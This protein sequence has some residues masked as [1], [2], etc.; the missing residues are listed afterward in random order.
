MHLKTRFLKPRNPSAKRLLG[1]AALLFSCLHATQVQAADSSVPDIGSILKGPSV[2]ASPATTPKLS[3][4]RDSAPTAVF[5]DAV[6]IAVTNFIISGN[7]IFKDEQLRPLLEHLRGKSWT[8]AQLMTSV[9][10]ITAFYEQAG[11]PLVSVTIPEQTLDNGVLRLEVLE[12]VWGDVLL[13]QPGTPSERLI[14]L[15]TQNLAK[16][17]PVL[18]QEIDRSTA[19]LGDIAG[20]SVR[21]RLRPGMEFGATNLL[22]SAERADSISGELAVNNFGGVA[23]G[24]AQATMSLQLNGLVSQGE[25]IALDGMSAG[26]GM[27]WLRA[28]VELPLPVQAMRVGAAQSV[29]QYQLVGDAKSLGAHGWAQ[30]T[31]AWVKHALLQWGSSRWSARVQWDKVDLDDLLSAGAEMSNRR[32]IQMWG[33]SLGSELAEVWPGGGRARFTLGMTQGQLQFAQEA[34]QA[35]DAALANTQGR[36]TRLN[37]SGTYSQDIS[38]LD[39]VTG[40]VDMQWSDRNLDASQKASLGGPRSVRGFEAGVLSGDGSVMSV[41][42]LRHLWGQWLGAQWS[43]A[44]FVDYGWIKT[45]AKAWNASNNEASIASVGLGLQGQS[46]KQWR[47]NLSIAESI[48]QLPTILETSRARHGGVWLEFVKSL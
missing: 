30:Q 17:Q 44:M 27:Q 47:I 12:A 2:P 36:F 7:L 34:A 16:G 39:S 29:V 25:S 46:A 20:L 23:T 26:D 38:A 32:G 11:Y 6:P 4:T 9:Q 28:S 19:L 37:L 21:A 14:R 24:R 10:A 42:E 45:N 31:S 43:S 48:G 8:L 15:A 5:D 33:V 22:V 3:L 18:Q 1:P 40:S 41:F 35:N 13:E